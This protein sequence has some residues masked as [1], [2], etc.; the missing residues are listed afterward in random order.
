MA[1]NPNT[2]YYLFEQLANV[3]DKLFSSLAR[4]IFNY[5]EAEVKDNPMYDK[6]ESETD[7]WFE[8]QIKIHKSSSHK[9]DIP[10]NF[11]DTKSLAYTLFKNIS[12]GDYQ[13]YLTVAGNLFSHYEYAVSIN[14][15]KTI[16]LASFKKAVLED[17]VNANPEIKEF[18]PK[19]VPGTTAFIVHGHDN[20]V[21]LEV[22]DLLRSAGVHTI[23]LHE[24]ANL[25]RTIPEKLIQE[26]EKAGYAIALLTPDDIIEG[27]IVRARQNVIL[28]IG[29]FMGKLGK[30]RVTLLLKGNLDIPSDLQG[31]L[32]TRYD[33]SGAWKSKILIELIALG[34]KAD[35]TAAISSM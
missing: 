15:F 33:T 8:W 28:E 18:N 21:K 2:L 13:N 10:D 31:M 30:E 26:S 35:L 1:L 34:I 32:Y 12:K 23:I 6:Y 7:K 11:E 3:D 5:L 27:D 19:H 17:I 14:N 29:Y 24:V 22:K 25:G 20:E 9:W 4:Q 16:F